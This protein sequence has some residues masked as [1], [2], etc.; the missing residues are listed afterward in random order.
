MT[1]LLYVFFCLWHCTL[2]YERSTFCNQF[3]LMNDTVLNQF[4]MF[5]TYKKK[6][7]KKKEKRIIDRPTQN[8]KFPTWGQ[9]NKKDLEP[10]TLK[11]RLFLNTVNFIPSHLDRDTAKNRG[12]NKV[13]QFAAFSQH[14]SNVQV[15]SS[16]QFRY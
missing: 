6:K 1:C 7:L 9:H 14:S 11:L 12:E 16:M 13:V 8:F 4:W 5:E 10:Y 3:K 15:H 2:V